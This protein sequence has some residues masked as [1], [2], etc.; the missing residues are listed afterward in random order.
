MP[1]HTQRRKFQITVKSSVA[2]LLP[3]IELVVKLDCV[4]SSGSS[5]PELA[6]QLRSQR[7]HCAK[8]FEDLVSNVAG[9][10]SR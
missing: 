7:P 4:A 10:Y 8:G 2:N 1:P 6:T 9:C 3:H 5:A